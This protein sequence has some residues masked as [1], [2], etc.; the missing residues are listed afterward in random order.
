MHNAFYM[1]IHYV[2]TKLFK[3][4][5]KFLWSWLAF[6]HSVS[7]VNIFWKHGFAWLFGIT[8]RKNLDSVPFLL[9]WYMYGH[10]RNYLLELY[11]NHKF[12]LNT[13]FN[14]QCGKVR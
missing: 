6:T 10:A 9:H 4:L 12:C 8:D 13:I 5:L 11:L 2:K 1:L 7:L 14:F 3:R